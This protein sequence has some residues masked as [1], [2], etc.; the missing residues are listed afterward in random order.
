MN[1]QK[2]N[3]KYLSF[4]LIPIL[5]YYATYSWEVV[6]K[7]S[8]LLGTPILLYAIWIYF[9]H[10]DHPIYLLGDKSIKNSVLEGCVYED[11]FKD[12]QGNTIYDLMFC[13]LID[14]EQDLEYM[15]KASSYYFYHNI[16][17]PSKFNGTIVVSEIKL[18]RHEFP[19]S[20]LCT[21]KDFWANLK[22][23]GKF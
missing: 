17:P 13:Q 9:S 5:A 15:D 2:R 22:K 23:L 3:F 11:R 8:I 19:N 4:A 12:D 1:K 10:S 6:Y 18:F 16:K 14:V 20:S 21:Q 7:L